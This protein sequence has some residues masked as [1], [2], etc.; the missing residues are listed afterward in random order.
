MEMLM[1][2]SANFLSNSMEKNTTAALM[3]GAMMDLSG[4]PLPMTLI[5]IR[6]MDSALMNVSL[7]FLLRYSSD[8]N[9]IALQQ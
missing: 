7:T 1:E 3:L 4:A 2:N 8:C 9:I 6:N 5:K